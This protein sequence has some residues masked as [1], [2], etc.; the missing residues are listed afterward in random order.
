MPL[1]GEMYRTER[2]TLVQG[3]CLDVL[4]CLEDGEAD[5]LVTDPPYGLT[6]HGSH[7]VGFEHCLRWVGF[8][9]EFPDFHKPDA[10]PSK[11]VQFS[12]VSSGTD[13]LHGVEGGVDAGVSVPVSA[14]NL[15]GYSQ[16]SQPEVNDHAEPSQPISDNSL[17]G[18]PDTESGQLLGDCV[19]QLRRS[20]DLTF[21]K[22]VCS[23]FRQ[24]G[25]GLWS[26]T[27]SILGFPLAVH[28][29]RKIGK[30][31]SP[32]RGDV[33]SSNNDTSREPSRSPGIVAGSGAE[34]TAMLTIDLR[35]RTFYLS[36][37]EGADE[38]RFTLLHLGS[39]EV[40]TLT[41]TGCLPTPAKSP[42]VCSVNPFANRAL[43]INR[44]FLHHDIVSKL[45]SNIPRSGFMGKAWDGSGIAFSVDFWREVLRVMKPGAVLLAFCGTRTYHRMAS[46]I[47]DAGFILED[48]LMWLHGQGFPKHKSKLKPGYEP[49]ILARKPGPLWLGVEECRIGS[50]STLRNTTGARDGTSLNCAMD[51]S[52]SKPMVTGASSGRWPANTVLSHHPE[53]VCQGTKNV[54]GG[55]GIRGASTTIYGGGKGFTKATG[56]EVGYADA[57][58]TETVEKWTCHPDCP[59]RLLDEQAGERR[60]YCSNQATAE[61]ASDKEFIN[62]NRAVY[63]LSKSNGKSFV[64]G[65]MYADKGGASRFFA[66]FPAEEDTSRMLYCSKASKKDRCKGLEGLEVISIEVLVPTDERECTWERVGQ[67]VKLR[68]DTERL[69]PKATVAFGVPDST[70]SE[71]SMFLFGSSATAPFLLDN[72]FT[73]GTITPSITESKTLS[74]LTPLLTRESIVD[75]SYGMV[76][77]GSPV[78]NAKSC[79][80]SLSITIVNPVSLPGVG[81]VASGTRLLITG[82]DGSPASHPTVK[83]TTLMSWLVKLACPEG[84]LVL[85]PFAGSGS[86]GVACLRTGRRFLGVE[87]DRESCLTAARRLRAEEEVA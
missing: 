74:W 27:V 85:D 3:D 53:C 37:A 7:R 25:P 76:S 13:S 52:L 43:P 59:I 18:K 11:F 66:N 60:S 6:A 41:R 68:V 82:N 2:A 14:V 22:G 58:G 5:A 50:E 69:P 78:V 30:V 64:R 65:R 39:E 46:A 26:V 20:A 45:S 63:E 28:R 33:V 17:S 8:N 31:G 23:C 56:E 67:K 71:W 62:K 10:S 4:R 24:L 84:G 61:A 86:T 21:C 77:G 72:A 9:V 1:V 29:T 36:P 81:H 75:A 19:L 34:Q 16:V 40:R 15:K 70:V 38:P 73:I 83:S 32:L 54:K 57:D 42:G 79:N 55:N 80:P 49:I 51:G 47:E 87:S 35:R 48:C 12:L 44:I